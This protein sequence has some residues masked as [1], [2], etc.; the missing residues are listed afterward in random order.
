MRRLSLI[1]SDLYVPE[2]AGRESAHADAL[3]LPNLAWLLRFSRDPVVLSDWRTWLA[4]RAG[5]GALAALPVAHVA[6]R[7]CVD[8]ALTESAW[9]ATPVRLEARLDHVRLADRGLLRVGDTESA[10]WCAEFAREFGPDVKL[11][12]AGS[13]GFVLTGISAADI[14][15]MD[16]ARL[17]DS[18]VA[19]A[20]PRGAGAATLRRLGA[21]LEMWLHATPLNAQ[22]EQ[23]GTTRISAFWLW[24]GGA[25]ADV[26]PADLAHSPGGT[27]MV[28]GGDPYLAGLA[29]AART[30]RE[31]EPPAE[32]S[33]LDPGVDHVI[34]LTPMSD[35]R[36][37]LVRLEE[38]WFA[39]ARAALSAGALGALDIIANDRWFTIGARP[40]W[41][42]WRK[43]RGWLASLVRPAPASK[44]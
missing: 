9:L 14:T 11:H 18:D 32:F 21:E 2:E 38:R 10:R 13:R 40:G 42:W 35:S 16:P 28:H 31:V 37:T 3:E 27:F 8:P 1:L 43:R 6:A 22:R 23:A 36:A 24:G 12:P 25:V 19:Q 17:L 26:S 44:A 41:R 5:L 15:T 34:E 33:A 20:L 4:A 30:L 29:D 39:P 7:T